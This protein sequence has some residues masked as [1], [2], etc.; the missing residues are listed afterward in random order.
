MS[1]QINTTGSLD[2][3]RGENNK[4]DNLGYM[5]LQIDTMGGLDPWKV[6]SSI[7]NDVV[8]LPDISDM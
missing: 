4:F 7:S 2:P 8:F 6:S 1:L 5:P 3:Q